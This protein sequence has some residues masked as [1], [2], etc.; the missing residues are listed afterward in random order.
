[1]YRSTLRV[2]L[3]LL[4]SGFLSAC[5]LRDDAGRGEVGECPVQ[6]NDYV[7]GHGRTGIQG[8]VFIKGSDEPLTEAFVNIYSDTI[9]NLLGPS[10]FISQPTDPAGNYSL[11]LSPGTYYVVARKRMSGQ[12]TG[13]LSPGDF[14]SEHQRIVTT[15]VEGKISRV[16]LEVVPMKAPMFFKREVVARETDTGIRGIL[17]DRPGN[18]VAGGFAMAY[19]DQDLKRL[20]DY[21]STLSDAEGRFTIYLPAG[22][23][24]YLAARI[25]AWDMPR[26]GEPYGILGGQ[27]PT[28]VVVEKGH[29]VEGLIIEMAPFAGEYKPGK[30]RRPY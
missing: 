8:K 22:G 2:L 10:R 18:P 23:T 20:P 21:G 19:S 16:D 25:H 13:P 11:E 1:M 3:L 6:M 12:S 26:T 29:F 28:P 17:L 5:A 9:S 4:V 27:T 24:Y 14:Y 30:S 7:D 15:V